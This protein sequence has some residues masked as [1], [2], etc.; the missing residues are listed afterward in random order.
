MT[1][2]SKIGLDA[3]ERAH[4]ALEA[5]PQ[6]QPDELTKRQAVQN[7]LGPIRATR[8]KGYSLAAISKLFSECGIPITTGALRAYLSDASGAGGKKKRSRAKPR[9][10][11]TPA[12]R[13]A[14][15]KGG[16]S[17][18]PVR[19]AM[20][21]GKPTA[22]APARNADLEWDLAAPSVEAAVAKDSAQH[23]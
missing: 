9:A 14:V 18:T 5:L 23:S 16:P 3:V 13:A 19:P 21:L 17:A 22:G 15:P 6:H 20:P 7:L 11:A 4:R 1:V 8:A 2:K 12:A 10:D